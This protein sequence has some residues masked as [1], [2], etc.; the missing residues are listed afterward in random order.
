M[1]IKRSAKILKLIAMNVQN[2]QFPKQ[3]EHYHDF[4]LLKLNADYKQ[5]EHFDDYGKVPENN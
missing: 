4:F 5:Q 1:T 2:I 3:T